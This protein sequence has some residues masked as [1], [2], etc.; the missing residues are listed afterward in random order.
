MRKNGG[1]ER[2]KGGGEGEGDDEFAETKATQ[3][4]IYRWVSRE[5]LHDLIPQVSNPHSHKLSSLQVP[6]SVLGCRGKSNE[7]KY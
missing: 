3:S 5:L 7:Y 2:R 6:R 4:C 1:R